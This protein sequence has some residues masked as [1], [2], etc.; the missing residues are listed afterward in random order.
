MGSKE[1][2]LSTAA[3]F[4]VGSIKPGSFGTQSK[5]YG[6]VQRER[7][8]WLVE[9]AEELRWPSDR[10]KDVDSMNKTT[11]SRNLRADE[12]MSGVPTGFHGEGEGEGEQG[13]D[14]WDKGGEKVGTVNNTGVVRNGTVSKYQRELIGQEGDDR[15]NEVYEGAPKAMGEVVVVFPGPSES[16]G[17]KGEANGRRRLLLSGGRRGMPKGTLEERIARLEVGKELWGATY[18]PPIEPTR[19][20][21][22]VDKWSSAAKV[23]GRGAHG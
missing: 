14:K 20:Q 6:D 11:T 18:V 21:E 10:S 13:I 8:R 23:E 22:L 12:G 2:A 3:C 15:E 19:R 7:Q 5:Y 1:F 4:S 16:A 9:R 17:V